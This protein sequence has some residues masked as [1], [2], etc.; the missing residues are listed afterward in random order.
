[1]ANLLALGDPEDE[2][3]VVLPAPP[4][5]Q[6]GSLLFPTETRP[7]PVRFSAWPQASMQDQPSLGPVPYP[8]SRD[9]ADHSAVQG[10]MQ[11]RL[12][13]AATLD[14]SAQVAAACFAAAAS[15]GQ[16]AV[17]Q[18]LA[19]A[20]PELATSAEVQAAVLQA[21]VDRDKA[22]SLQWMLHASPCAPAA[23]ASLSSVLARAAA[24]GAA[25]VVLSVLQADAAA[26]KCL[27]VSQF[28][29]GIFSAA[30][31]SGET[32]F[33]QAVRGIV[34]PSE[35]GHRWGLQSAASK[36]HLA[37]VQALLQLPHETLPNPHGIGGDAIIA[38][39]RNGHAAVA[40]ELLAVPP[41]RQVTQAMVTSLLPQLAAS[42]FAPLVSKCLEFPFMQGVQALPT[43]KQAAT[44]GARN[45]R[46]HVVELLLPRCKPAG[47]GM[48][49]LLTGGLQ[50]HGAFISSLVQA[51]G[52]GL[53]DE[54]AALVLREAMQAGVPAAHL[55]LDW[56]LAH[57]LSH[58]LPLT[59][60]ALLEFPRGSPLDQRSLVSVCS[61]KNTA[62]L[63]VLVEHAALPSL[64]ALD[65]MQAIKSAFDEQPAA[66][67]SHEGVLFVQEAVA[68]APA[69]STGLTADAV[70]AFA[71]AV[72]L[73]R[74]LVEQQAKQVELVAWLVCVAC[75][76]VRGAAR[77]LGMSPVPL[78]LRS[79]AATQGAAAFLMDAC[80]RQQ[81]FW[82]SPSLALALCHAVGPAAFAKRVRDAA[83]AMSD[84]ELLLRALETARWKKRRCILLFR[85][86][87]W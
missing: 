8:L 49:S 75:P 56:P 57:C 69:F 40:G 10:C 84:V 85:K 9:M 13:S 52:F 34:V 83:G 86:C 37:V 71:T 73:Y 70:L 20:C 18:G 68:A 22:G 77:L 4:P 32:D 16:V 87:R 17:L 76:S 58:P 74:P 46:G 27:Q 7:P 12:P 39:A 65:C 67:L 55:D 19:Q 81:Q 44:E 59:L 43:I 51:A 15:S 35:A 24:R 78:G 38:A 1:M 5:P 54:C 26:D 29:D 61:A 80:I 66:F 72:A 53:H 21:A 11:G 33:M 47:S 62:A 50:G 23:M 64:Q 42:G 82:E 6:P 2:V 45:G 60:Q 14:S 36:G 41:P 63:A 30:C 28:A 79:V 3:E 31:E 48:S 25:Q